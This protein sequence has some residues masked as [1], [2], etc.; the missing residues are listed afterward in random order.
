METNKSTLETALGSGTTFLHLSSSSCRKQ[1]DT[2]I[3]MC[4]PITQTRTLTFF[5][6]FLE[7]YLYEM[8]VVF[9]EAPQSVSDLG[10]VALLDNVEF[11]FL[12][13]LIVFLV[14]K[15]SHSPAN[16][17]LFFGSVFRLQ[18]PSHPTARS[19]P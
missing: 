15:Q 16:Q 17:K 2:N 4:Y 5:G 9:V 12:Q 11:E 18:G 6:G 8:E 3:Q 1:R 19:S 10:L 14:V 13:W 7:K